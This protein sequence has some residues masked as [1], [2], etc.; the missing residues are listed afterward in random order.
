MTPMDADQDDREVGTGMG[1]MSAILWLCGKDLRPSAS[2][3]DD[4]ILLPHSCF[5]HRVSRLLAGRC[6]LS[7]GRRLMR[8][9]RDVVGLS[10]VTVSELEF[11]AYKSGDYDTEI[12]AVR[13]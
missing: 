4:L 9:T 5:H 11:G 8:P 10:A 3:V 6:F 1:Q 2:S 13:K 7:H 12:F